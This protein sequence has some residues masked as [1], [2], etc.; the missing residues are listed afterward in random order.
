MSISQTTLDV[1]ANPPLP[2]DDADTFNEKAF[3]FA[4]I[5]ETLGEEMNS[6]AA[7]MNL[8]S[9]NSTSGTSLPIGATSK[10]LTV[11]AGK[12]YQIGM[13][14][15][16]AYTTTPSNYMAGQVTSYNSTTGALVVNVQSIGG[17]G[18]F[19]NWTIS[20][21]SAGFTG[22]TLTSGMNYAAPVTLASASTVAIGAA[23]SNVILISGSTTINAFDSIPAGAVRKLRFALALTLT[24]NATSMI[25]PGAANIAVEAG[26][27]AEFT[28]LGSGNWKC[29]SYQRATPAASQTKQGIVEVATA[30][31]I[32][33]ADATRVATGGEMLSA[34]GF[35][36]YGESAQQTITAAG[37]LTLAHGLG[38]A[39]KFIDSY[40]V[41][42]TAEFGWSVG[43]VVNLGWFAIGSG[44]AA[45]P[46]GFVW[47]SD[48]TNLS[49]LFGNGAGAGNFQLPNKSTG[50]LANANN[51]SWKI[52]FRYWG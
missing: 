36:A 19:S 12:S 47:W 50:N 9:T 37:T 13:W 38:R 41:C 23:A 28:S 22:G 10:S 39:V 17:G 2:T 21:A 15:I 11:Q 18:T 42:T 7:A 43:D 48:T 3:A 24:Y 25:L 31:E 27:E 6:T 46:Q 20:Q 32:K 5:Q 16:I 35:T 4:A 49:I 45:N 33:S 51:S 40:L 14:V 52:V 1:L 29:T 8:N 30:A 34:M 26:D 44:T